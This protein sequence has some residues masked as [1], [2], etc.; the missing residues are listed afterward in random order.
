MP[1]HAKNYYGYTLSD[2]EGQDNVDEIA[3]ILQNIYSIDPTYDNWS[4]ISVAALCGNVMN[5][6]ELNPWRWEGDHVPTVSEFEGWTQ[7]QGQSHGY[8]LF[9][10]TPPWSYIN[11]VNETNLYAWGY[12]PNFLDSAGNP[13]DGDA[14][15][16]YM[17]S[18]IKPNWQNRG[19]NFVYNNF[20]DS[21]EF[22]GFNDE[23]ISNIANMT[24]D[25]FIDGTG[26]TVEELAAAY[27]IKF[28]NPS[29]NPLTNHIDRRIASAVEAYAYLT[30][31]PPGP[32]PLFI[33]QAN[34]WKFYLY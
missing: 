6:G 13:N 34:T 24:Y 19:P 12:A 20:L 17:L 15:L 30:G 2:Q 18:I 33:T 26:Y 32:S 16:V 7:G 9:G 10:F 3:T 1:W 25:D 4:L 28:E 22:A 21:L 31:N 11:S 8:G 5:E 27:M 14:Q 29:H 23:Q